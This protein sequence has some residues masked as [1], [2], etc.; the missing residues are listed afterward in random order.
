[1]KTI[2]ECAQLPLKKQI[3][4]Y[5]LEKEKVAKPLMPAKVIEE[6]PKTEIKLDVAT[7]A[8][9]IRVDQTVDKDKEVK[10]KKTEPKPLNAEVSLLIFCLFILRSPNNTNIDENTHSIYPIFVL[11]CVYIIYI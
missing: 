3:V 1:M 10:S 5:F 2:G 7:T 9:I 11:Y 6:A 8:P 4:I